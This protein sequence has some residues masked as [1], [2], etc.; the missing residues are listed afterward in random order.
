MYK[1]IPA[2]GLS[3]PGIWECEARSMVLASRV[4]QGGGTAVKQFCDRL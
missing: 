4:S 2:S 1:S 3:V